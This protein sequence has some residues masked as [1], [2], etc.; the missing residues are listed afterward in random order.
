MRNLLLRAAEFAVF[1]NLKF[2]RFCPLS[3][4]TSCTAARTPAVVLSKSVCSLC[5]QTCVYIKNMCARYSSRI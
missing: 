4:T 3:G 2:S 1:S 5:L